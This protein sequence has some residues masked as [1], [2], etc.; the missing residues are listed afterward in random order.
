MFI[1]SPIAA[2]DIIGV[3]HEAGVLAI[4]A[5]ISLSVCL[6]A[7]LPVFFF[8]NVSLCLCVGAH[9]CL[10][11]SLS[12]AAYI[13]HQPFTPCALECFSSQLR[14]FHD[15]CFNDHFQYTILSQRHN[16]QD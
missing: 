6:Y 16:W 2:V 5:G 4:P 15:K 11:L 1:T 12:V 7:R 8:F 13:L 14:P 10:S 3:C 9:A